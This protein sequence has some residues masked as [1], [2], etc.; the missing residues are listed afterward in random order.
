MTPSRPELTVLFAAVDQFAVTLR[1]KIGA[2]AAN[3]R[4]SLMRDLSAR[5]PRK[6][7]LTAT[8]EE[9]QAAGRILVGEGR[10]AE[11][12]HTVQT[13]LDELIQELVRTGAMAYNPL[14]D[15]APDPTP[16]GAATPPEVLL[17][18]RLPKDA[19]DMADQ[20]LEPMGIAVH[21]ASTHQGALDQIGWFPFTYILSSVPS[22]APVPFLEAI[23][24]PGSMCRSAGVIFFS[25]DHLLEEAAIFIG[26]GANRVITSS[27]LEAQLQDMVTELGMVSERTKVRLKVYVDFDDATP[28]DVWHSENVSATGMLVRTQTAIA[29]G[30]EIDL[31]FTVPG[32]DL[33]IHARAVVVRQTTFAREDFPGLAVRFLSFVGEGQHRLSLFL[34]K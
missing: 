5:L 22:I 20:L 27:N 23:R 1:E 9:I 21:G 14:R 8:R 3:S 31:Q 28:S 19:F 12:V 15:D 18:V 2:E 30:V 10:T 34:G 32:D 29:K 7:L 24:A 25:K 11:E 13:T 26:R 4:L 17:A 6:Y 16:R 33:P